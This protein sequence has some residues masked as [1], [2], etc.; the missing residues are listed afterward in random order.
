MCP[1]SA[2]LGWV[3]I[4]ANRHAG[5]VAATSLEAATKRTARTV[6]FAYMVADRYLKRQKKYRMGVIKEYYD[7]CAKLNSTPKC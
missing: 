4:A 1:K 7:C 2:G 3:L 6:D 5:G